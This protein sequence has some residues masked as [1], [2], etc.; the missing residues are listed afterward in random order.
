MRLEKSLRAWQASRG[1]TASKLDKL[2]ARMKE[3]QKRSI[4]ER[5]AKN[6]KSLALVKNALEMRDLLDEESKIIRK[7]NRSVLG[8]TVGFY[9]FERDSW[10]KS[11]RTTL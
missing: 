1:E 10:G 2:D 4:A 9:G 3:A 7:Y 6:P 5:F 11:P 8:D